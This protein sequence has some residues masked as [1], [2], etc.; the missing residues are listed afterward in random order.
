MSIL[1]D[2]SVWIDHLRS[3][4]LEL[5]ARLETGLVYIHPFVVGELACGNLADRNKVLSTLRSLPHAGVAGDDEVLFYIE[6]HRISGK[7]L[8][9]L[10]MHLLAC[11]AL[12]RL[13]LWTLDRRLAQV[14]AEL[15]LQY[16]A[17]E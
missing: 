2:T 14:A 8:G 3:S 17:I 6:K 9:Y 1:V 16:P 7:G 11:A 5:I 4:N 12:E 13:Q 10:D 15:G